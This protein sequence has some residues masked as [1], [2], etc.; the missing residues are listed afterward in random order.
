ML[1]IDGI[2]PVCSSYMIIIYAL[3]TL[4]HLLTLL[5]AALLAFNA[6]MDNECMNKS[7]KRWWRGAW[8]FGKGINLTQ[9]PMDIGSL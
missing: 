3:H 2:Y 1:Y 5:A 8:K 7:V 4:W 9:R 6:F